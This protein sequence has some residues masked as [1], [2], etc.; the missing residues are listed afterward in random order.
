MDGKQEFQK[1]RSAKDLGLSLTWS[2]LG[3][4]SF[5]PV[6]PEEWMEYAGK[7]NRQ[8][9]HRK[10]PRLTMIFSN[11][12]LHKHFLCKLSTQISNFFWNQTLS[13]TTT[14]W[15][16]W[17]S[18]F[19]FF[20]AI[21]IFAE[22]KIFCKWKAWLSH[23]FLFFLFRSWVKRKSRVQA[24]NAQEETISVLQESQAGARRRKCI[25]KNVSRY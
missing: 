3:L 6:L 22:I 17:D 2:G 19:A 11:L 18:C 20:A 15:F 23:T 21:A 16:I 12:P 5:F 8:S 25:K 24:R 13:S 4:A 7:W 1:K 10:Q 9:K 14:D